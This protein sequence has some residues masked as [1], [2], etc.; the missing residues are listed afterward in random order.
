VTDGWTLALAPSQPFDDLAAGVLAQAVMA[1]LVGPGTV[2]DLRGPGVAVGAAAV[3]TGGDV[4]GV[5]LAGVHP[6]M[7]FAV[8]GDGGEARW[9]ALTALALDV[10][11]AVLRDP[12]GSLWL[13]R[14][15]G[16]LLLSDDDDHWP[17]ESLDRVPAA[18]ARRPL[19]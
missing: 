18:Y 12:A 14:R 10:G 6:T 1:G 17:V 7:W 3:L 16:E 15:D 11:D 5:E 13:V 19:R 4:E 9:L 2:A 8:T